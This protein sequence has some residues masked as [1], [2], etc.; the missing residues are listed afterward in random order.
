MLP[1]VAL[2]SF[3]LVV[4]TGDATQISSA[5][6]GLPLLLLELGYSRDFE[7]EAD[8]F[9]HAIMVAERVPLRAF[10]DILT[11][12]EAYWDEPDSDEQKQEDG[13]WLRYLATHPPNDE[14]ARLFATDEST[15]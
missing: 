10:P 13:D 12:M 11:R 7:R 3:V 8:R 5:V 1:L 6:A 14:R 15:D 9:A 4:I 2:L